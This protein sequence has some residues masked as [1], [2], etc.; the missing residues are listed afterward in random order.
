MP[1]F[2][3]SAAN[4]HPS[5][6]PD[7][8]NQAIDYWKRRGLLQLW[9]GVIGNQRLQHENDATRKN[10]EAEEAH[11]R[12]N[13]WGYTDPEQSEDDMGHTILGD[14]NNPAPVVYPP[15]QASVLPALAAAALGA[16]VPA[17]GIGGYL[18][19]Q[20]VHRSGSQ[21]EPTPATAHDDESVNLGL[22][23]IEDYLAN[24][25]NEH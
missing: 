13:V 16:L 8:K 18:L 17:A 14:I 7:L 3:N 19:S 9:T 5:Q 12:K 25:T 10:R 23:R 4:P 11:V 6:S 24:P 22:G 20:G 21:T 2:S 1:S 15:P